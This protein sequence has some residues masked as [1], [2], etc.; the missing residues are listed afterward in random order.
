MTYLAR[1]LHGEYEQVWDDLVHL[2]TK[3]RQERFYTDAVAV[4]RETMRRVRKNV[5]TLIERLVQIGFIFGYDHRIQYSLRTFQTAEERRAYLETLAWARQQPPVFLSA[6]QI[7]EERG[8]QEEMMEALFTSVTGDEREMLKRDFQRVSQE[9]DEKFPSMSVCIGEIEQLI[10]PVPLSIRAWYE[11]VG[12][13]N[14]AGYHPDWQKYV[15]AL[16]SENSGRNNTANIHP[17]K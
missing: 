2:G 13:V 8:E 6:H 12:G 3:V 9:H 4:A 15:N 7:E 17:G 5:E 10:G 11:I 14:F 16:W 1:Y